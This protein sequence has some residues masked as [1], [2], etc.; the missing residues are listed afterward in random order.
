MNTAPPLYL[1]STSRY[2]ADLLGRLALPFR[3]AAPHCDERP[4]PDE[5]AAEL[6]HRL[7]STKA[8]S[9]AAE[10]AD[11]LIIG[12]DQIAECDGNLL[13]KPGN[14]ERATQQLQS[15]SGRR[16]TFHTG[17]CLLDA[18]SGD[19]Q[20]VV[21]PFAVVFRPLD[22]RQIERYLW[23][24]K[25]FDC[26]GSF[27]SEGLGIALFERFEGRD[28]TALIGLPLMRLVA[29]LAQAGVEVP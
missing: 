6:V 28:P 2:R 5:S 24:E 19:H 7:A 21:E 16:V 12:S 4:L 8:A 11:A 20:T 13:G 29:L 9:V 14:F 27:K 18:R 25:P 22:A 1:A 23:K 3:T 26:A 15:L 10:H 17:L